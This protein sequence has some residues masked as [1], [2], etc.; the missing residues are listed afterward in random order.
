MTSA[1]LQALLWGLSCAVVGVVYA[2]VLAGEHT[3]MDPWYRLL[4]RYR[5][6]LNHR[7][8]APYRGWRYWLAGMVGG[9]EKCFSGQL[10]LWSS[11]ALIHWHLSTASIVVHFTA[12]GWAVLFARTFGF[13]YKWMEKQL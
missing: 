8:N 2:V 10:A 3:P 7:T 5:D 12:A 13:W 9:C 6:D 4:N 1:L 11:S